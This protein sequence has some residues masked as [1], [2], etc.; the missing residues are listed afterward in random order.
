[1][2]L[3]AILPRLPRGNRV[4]RGRKLPLE[5]VRKR[6]ESVIAVTR[7]MVAIEFRVPSLTREKLL[8]DADR[9]AEIL[10]LTA[11]MG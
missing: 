3:V 11:S 4:A 10:R 8:S 2:A 6:G 7:V 9:G 1:M 5:T